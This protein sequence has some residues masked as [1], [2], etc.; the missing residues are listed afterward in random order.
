MASKISLWTDTVLEVIAIYVVTLLIAATL[1]GWLEGHDWITSLYWAG[2]T[3]T[4]TGYGDV[5]PKT[6]LGMFLAF[7]LQ[8][9]G[10][11]CIAP[12]LIIQLTSKII[13]DEHKFTHEEQEIHK[14]QIADLHACICKPPEK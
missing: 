13:K 8:H 2:T 3:A 6:S 1:F 7:M 14:K 10:I 4:S 12:L 5:V 11:F 9:V